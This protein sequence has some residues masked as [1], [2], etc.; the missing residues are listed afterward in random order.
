MRDGEGRVLVDV[1]PQ[2]DVDPSAFRRSLEGEGL[3]VS[4]VDA[5]TGTVE[6]YLALS[7]VRD[8]AALPGLGTNAQAIK[9]RT[10]TGS[11]E[12]Q[13]V[14]FQRI[15]KV[16]RTGI[17]GR[18]ITVGVLSDSF[19]TATTTVTGDPLTIHA[20]DDIA[21]GDLPGPGNAKHPQPVTVLEDAP[22]EDEGRAMLQVIHDI[23]PDAKLCFATAFSGEVGFANNIRALADPKGKCRADV[24]VD[25]VSYFDEPFFADGI[26][27]DAVDDVAKLGVQYYS[28]AGN[29]G[30]DNGWS[31]PVRLL[32]ASKALKGTDLDLTG[33]DPA[34]YDG[35]FADANPGA[36]TD[37]AQT[38]TTGADGGLLDLQWDDPTD[39]DGSTIGDP[40]FTDQGE[41]T[42]PTSEVVSTFT[43]TAAQIG[44][45]VQFVVDGVPSGTT[46]VVIT[47]TK[48]DGT[49][50]GPIDT[51][52]SPEQ[53]VTT[54]NQAGAYRLSVTGF[55]GSTGPFTV[56]VSPILAPSK[57]TTDFNALIFDA[58]GNYL[59][60]LA[61][62]NRLS[63]RPLEL[64]Q[65]P[66]PRELQIVVSRSGTGP[67][68]VR[69]LR[70]VA[71]GDLFFTEYGDPLS[72][73]VY[74]HPA[75]A[76]ATGVAAVDPF[77]PYLP[78]YF[79]SPGGD[80]PIL[81][82]SSGD[83]Y[84]TTQVRRS[85]LVAATDGGNTTFFVSDSTEDADTLPN[86]FGTSEAA[87]HAAGIAALVLQKQ[88][89][90]R[91]VSPKAMKALL[92]KSTFA[93]DLD[94]FSASGSAGGL[95]VSASG[96]QGSERDPVPGTLNDPDF[97]RL[98]YSGSVPLKSVTFLGET[99]SPT[100]PGRTR[101]PLSDGIVFDP[102]PFSAAGPDFRDVGF[103]F[104]VG[105]T[106]GGLAASS[107]RA[108]FSAPFGASTGR[109]RHMTVTFGGTLRGGQ[110]LR[111]GVDR[112]LAV[113][114]YG[115][116]NEGNGAD[117]LGGAVF[118]PQRIVDPIGLTFVAVRADG[119][120]IVGVVKNRLGQGYSP[121]DGYGLIDA[122]KAV[123]NR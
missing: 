55:D 117:E 94:P 36:G 15:D 26:L 63:G 123:L 44:E 116:S 120:K 35:G 7:D 13:G 78:E 90:K 23:A 30:D 88:G 104:T 112:D 6:G 77:R 64:G 25:D 56:T 27:N 2:A 37:V 119:K 109:Y 100:A 111:F 8:V 92:S 59:G 115:G 70:A 118:A 76:G 60:A 82:D 87:P 53:I 91:S 79:T 101:P 72:P 58:D 121:V 108:S 89:G 12:S 80:L 105:G 46:D 73:T 40:Y 122:E 41:L 39:Y 16:L 110:S 113:S 67:T 22:G 71:N 95:T 45:Q 81:F 38:V 65:L 10:A 50:I 14:V 93:H 33:V 103:P 20:K 96:P 28:S 75:A 3:R 83:R 86:F 17:T 68:P 32:P 66:G 21:S 48:P 102:R 98:S 74:G 97:F 57:V 69:R 11:V 1:V 107:V 47:L 62:A 54:L 34:L 61:D 99:A 31:A 51:A 106:G 29:S 85:P 49:V 9:P 18:G 52:T 114:P 84:R 5:G 42:T 4:A 19:D 43:P 24:I